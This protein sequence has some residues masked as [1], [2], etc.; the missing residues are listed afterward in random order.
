MDDLVISIFITIDDFLQAE[1]IEEPKNVT[2][3]NSEILTTAIVAAKFFGNNFVMA[4]S[5]MKQH[6]IPAMLSKSQFIRRIYRLKKYL[7]RILDFIYNDRYIDV[8]DI[9]DKK[10]V[11][12]VDS[13]PVKICENARKNRCRLTKGYN[14]KYLGYIASKKEYVYGLKVS[15]LT[16]LQGLPVDVIIADASEHDIKIFDKHEMSLF[17]RSKIYADKAYNSRDLE[18]EL[19]RNYDVELL[20]IRKNN[21]KQEIDEQA[22]ALKYKRRKRIETTFS[23]IQFRF[24]KFLHCVKLDGLILKLF[25]AIVATALKLSGIT[26]I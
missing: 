20:P 17:S 10:E 5:Y 2:V 26:P 25:L 18:D 21:Y 15:V 9:E 16:T 13:F 7:T 4:M 24:P 11:Y 14:K 12:I 6:F 1:R 19:F 22:E 3:Y 8:S 23:E